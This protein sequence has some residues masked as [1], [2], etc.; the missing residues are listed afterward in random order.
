MIIVIWTLTSLPRILSA[1]SE[2]PQPVNVEII[3]INFIHMLTWAPGPGT[4]ADIYYQIG[5]NTD[6]GTAW[7][8]VTGCQHV[9]YPLVCN[10]T[11]AFS[12]PRQVYITQVTA[13]WR[14][15]V[16]RPA[17][18]PGFQPIKDTHLDLPVV[19]V[20]PCGKNL[21]V[22]LLPPMRHLWEF[23]NSLSYQFRIE[24]S[25][26]SRAPFFQKT[27]SLNGTVLKNLAPGRRYCISI[28]ISDR[29]VPRESNYSQQHCA[30]TP[31]IYTSD[32]VTSAVLCVISIAAIVIVILL[33]YTGFLCLRNIR[34]PS[35][36]TSIHHTKEVW[37]VVPRNASLSSLLIMPTLHSPW[38]E[39]D[40]Q[41]SDLWNAESSSGNGSGYKMRLASDLLCSSSP[42]LPVTSQ[43]ASLP[44]NTPNPNSVFS[45]VDVFSPLPQ[46]WIWDATS[47]HSST[48]AASLSDDLSNSD[49]GPVSDQASFTAERLHSIE[50]ENWE[51]EKRDDQDVNLHSLIWGRYV[52]EEQKNILD[53]RNVDTVDLQEHEGI[54]VMPP[55][56]WDAEGAHIEGTSCS[57]DEEEQQDEQFLYMRRPVSIL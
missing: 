13:K 24:S 3:S 14:A 32:S 46:A 10:M 7:V 44:N 29:L 37:V 56:T 57:D 31:G 12:D 54:S 21:C 28:R 23:Y 39:K 40:C 55:E 27:K 2:L 30:V 19:A 22:D 25:G 16:S 1:F 33:I 4:P 41:S 8:P 53:Q 6:V 42:S 48:N 50:V 36:L 18:H 9:Q 51:V 11:G 26:P 35:V 38:E 45:S 49:C 20:T 34:V 17:T 5:I 15:E 47:Q 52:E 43:P